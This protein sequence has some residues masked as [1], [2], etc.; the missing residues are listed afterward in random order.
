MSYSKKTSKDNTDNSISQTEI[1]KLMGISQIEK[2]NQIEVNINDWKNCI[3]CEKFHHKDYYAPNMNYCIHCW[4]W[5]NS[6]EY[7]LEKGIYYGDNSMEDIKK[8][9]KKAYPVH[10]ESKCSNTECVFNKIKKLGECKI[11]HSSIVELLEL[12]KKPKLE[13]VCFNYK[14]KNLAVNFDE[15]YIVI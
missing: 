3:Y 14:N 5:L 8:M 11:L 4:A 9:I 2:N 13:A 10:L 12:N 6:H 15:S 7:D 1:N